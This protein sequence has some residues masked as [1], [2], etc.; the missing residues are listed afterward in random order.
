MSYVAETE[1]D[2]GV[3]RDQMIMMF[4]FIYSVNRLL[5]LDND[6]SFGH[7]CHNASVTVSERNCK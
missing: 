5:P 1:R 3:V 2:Y 7:P 6:R 4:C